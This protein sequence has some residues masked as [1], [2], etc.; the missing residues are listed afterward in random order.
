MSLRAMG[1]V[2]PR[3]ASQLI[4]RRAC[5]L[6]KWTFPRAEA[7]R[8]GVHEVSDRI[9]RS[10]L[11][12][13]RYVSGQEALDEV[14]ALS[15][16]SLITTLLP[17]SPPFLALP[18]ACLFALSREILLQWSWFWSS[19]VVPWRY[20]DTLREQPACVLDVGAVQGHV[21]QRGRWETGGNCGG[22]AARAGE[23]EQVV[24][25]QRTA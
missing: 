2:L 7:V 10:F 4:S 5:L 23:G 13:K 18:P 3:F 17:S 11:S 9:V 21:V 12:C 24:R 14:L 6:M 19:C 20:R 15:F 1:G 25:R 8:P 22:R 16:V